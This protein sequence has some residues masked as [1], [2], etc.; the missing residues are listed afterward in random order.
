MLTSDGRAASGIDVRPCLVGVLVVVLFIF[1]SG[2]LF[3]A[4]FAAPV[5]CLGAVLLVRLGSLGADF[6][7]GRSAGVGRLALVV[8]FAGVVPAAISIYSFH[9]FRTAFPCCTPPNTN[10]VIDI[11]PGAWQVCPM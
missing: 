2:V 7:A 5:L 11:W 6:A 10:F 4:L 3:A 8:R 9:A 1:L